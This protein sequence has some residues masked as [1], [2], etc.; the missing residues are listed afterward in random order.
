[1]SFVRITL[2]GSHL[3][4]ISLLSGET[5]VRADGHGTSDD[6]VFERVDLAHGR[7]ALRT[8]DGRFLARHVAH[9]EM[10]TQAGPGI[11]HTVLGNALHLVEE[12]TPCAAFEELTA[13]DGTVSLRGCDH[14][15]LGV[16]P[17][18]SVVAGRVADGS[19]ERFRYVEAPA[20]QPSVPLEAGGLTTPSYVAR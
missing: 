12:L 10:V 16:S 1:M 14:R 19:W 6:G 18:G 2:E 4:A 20:P 15:F 8:H 3:R 7:I 5:R 17:D 13:A 11:D 9:P